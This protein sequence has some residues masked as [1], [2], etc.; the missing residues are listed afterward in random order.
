[1]CTLLA[2]LLL[3]SAVSAELKVHGLFRDGVVLQR[4]RAVPVWGT[5]RPGAEVAVSIAGQRKTAGVGTDGT[6]SVSL[7]PLAAGGPFELLIESGTRL[8]V[9]DVL[10]GEV[11]LVAGGAALDQPLKSSRVAL[12]LNETQASRLRLFRVPRGEADAPLKD[13]EGTWTSKDPRVTAEFSAVGYLFGVDLLERLQVPVG[14]I[15]ATGPEQP[16]E[17]WISGKGLGGTRASRAVTGLARRQAEAFEAAR[18][19]YRVAVKEALAR[20]EDPGKLP[21][22][23]RPTGPSRT[24]NAMLA[25]LAPFA[26]RGV[27]WQQGAADLFRGSEYDAFMQSLIQDWRGTWEQSDLPVGF[28]QMGRVGPERDEPEQSLW[29]ELREGQAKALRN[30]RSGMVPTFDLSAGGDLDARGI[31]E[32][33]RR[34]GLWAQAEVYGADVVSSGPQYESMKVEIDRIRVKFSN[35]GAG[36][37]TAGG[38]PLKGFTIS[39]EFNLFVKAQAKIEGDTVVVWSDEVRWPAAVRYGW[40]DHPA[41]TLA[42]PEGLPAI[43]F[44]TDRWPRR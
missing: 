37:V 17:Q 4:D 39:G 11:W 42:N 30:S 19:L 8:L 36:L 24:H 7:D 20:G 28:T 34:F 40:A 6:W 5:G 2:L 33:A 14:L 27:L 41:G 22:P 23:Q 9:R 3:Q 21:V 15:Q 38:A 1:M 10:V 16:L 35:A 44:R 26:L 13:L 32:L 31:R 29:A 25:P 18:T 12:T 43:P